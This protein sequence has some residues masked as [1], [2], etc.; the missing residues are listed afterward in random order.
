L[1]NRQIK[2]YIKN[3]LS[4]KDLDESESAKL[5]VVT[6]AIFSNIAEN[7]KKIGL[8]PSKTLEGFLVKVIQSLEEHAPN[9]PVDLM[10][11]NYIIDYQVTGIIQ[12]LL[13]NEMID[14]I[15]KRIP[16]PIEYLVDDWQKTFDNITAQVTSTERK[17]A[18]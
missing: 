5:E 2:E 9:T 11:T 13:Q 10:K 17:K 8:T 7:E 4:D 12:D 18:I 14:Q 1:K 15:I 16:F 3:N 6:D